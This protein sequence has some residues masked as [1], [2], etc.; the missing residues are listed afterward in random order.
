MHCIL[1]PNLLFQCMMMM[2]ISNVSF[3]TYFNFGRSKFVSIERYFL[4]ADKRCHQVGLVGSVW[5]I[6]TE[7]LFALRNGVFI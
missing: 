1:N 7:V 3:A 4:T 5:L 6:I 2:L